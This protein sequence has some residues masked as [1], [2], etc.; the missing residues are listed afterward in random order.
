MNAKNIRMKL[1]K[2]L[3]G[4][5]LLFSGL[6]V[7]AQNGL[8]SIHV[9][10]YYVSDAND[11]LYSHPAIP[12]GSVTYRIYADMLPGYKVQ[13]IY[14]S[15]VHSLLMNTTTYFFNQE[16]YGATIPTFSANNAKKNTVML[17]SWLTTGGACNGWNGILKAED[18]GVNN[19]VNSNVPPLLQNNAAQA[20]IPL[21]TQDG[22]IAGTVPSTITLGLDGIIEVFGDGSANGNTFLVTNGAWSCLSGAA[23]LDPITN[24]VLIAQITTDGIFHFELNI[25]IGTPSLGT[26]NYVASNPTGVELTIP[27]LIQTLYPVPAPPTVSITSPANGATFAIGTPIAITADANDADGTVSQVEFFVD[28]TSIGIDLSAPFEAVYTGTTEASHVLT[29]IATDNEGQSTISA[30][31]NFNVVTPLH[32]VTF[33]VDMSRE[34]VSPDG[35]H[36]AGNFNSWNPSA[37]PM[38]AGSDD[39]YSVTLPLSEGQE[40]TYRFVN[41]NSNSGLEFVP[42]ECGVPAGSGLF[43]RFVNIPSNDTIIDTV[44]FSMCAHCPADIPVTFR[45]DMTYQ[46][47]S[48]N[49]VHLAG[50]FNDWNTS[51]TP[52][53]AGTNNVYTATVML[54]PG[55]MQLFRF[56]NGNDSSGYES[57][58]AEC[59]SPS[60][61]GGYDRYF[62]IPYSDTTLTSVCF[63]SCVEC[64]SMPQYVNVTFRVDMH[65]EI[66][67]INGVHIAGSFQGWQPESTPM[68]TSG[69]TVYTYTQT[70]LSGTEI[71]Y[72]FVNGNTSNDLESVPAECAANGNRFLTIPLADTVL[73]LVCFSSCEACTPLTYANVTFRVDMSLSSVSPEG[74]HIMGNFQAWNPASTIMAGNGNIYSI[75][76]LLPVNTTY[77]YKFVNGITV[78]E[79]ENVPSECSQDGNR[80]F[81]SANDTILPLVCFSKCGICNV[82]L[83]DELGPAAIIMIS[84]NPF[85]EMAKLSINLLES[86]FI[87]LQVFDNI[88]QLT[89]TITEGNYLAGPHIFTLQGSSLKPGFYYCRLKYSS[90]EGEVVKTLKIIHK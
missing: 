64:G 18:N 73:N 6:F 61:L 3:L 10:R 80:Y 47:V 63:S 38:I 8:E 23:G 50:T 19:F 42:A 52:M 44:C 22:M 89:Y 77:E 53:A 30:P 9:E 15:S 90:P 82:G 65:H 35:I 75:T 14:G 86:G 60:A 45:V 41:G 12:V 34:S 43:N 70:F 29:A 5:F 17:D 20:G 76:M 11:A 78:N 71:Q 79:A 66:V 84:P 69:D 55:T 1:G 32:T 2:R 57:V 40:Y 13:S 31:V 81:L 21:T 27:S 33:I 36:I 85:G 83:A 7:Q 28:G 4:L 37:T 51:V 39:I 88:G 56:V 16:D 72:R 59:G 74:V 62:T 25:Q 48:P 68:V 46:T 26:E 67:S 87:S 58:P 24:K 49:G 54:P